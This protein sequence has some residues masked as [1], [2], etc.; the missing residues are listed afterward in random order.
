LEFALPYDA[1]LRFEVM[2]D[3]VVYNFTGVDGVDY[4]IAW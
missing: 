2:I 3:G 4:G 1:Y